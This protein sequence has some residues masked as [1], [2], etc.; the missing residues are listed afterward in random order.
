MNK[1][2][3]QAKK[4]NWYATIF[5]TYLFITSLVLILCSG[6]II[7]WKTFIPSS[8]YVLPIAAR[9]VISI[10][11]G[12]SIVIYGFILAWYKKISIYRFP[13]YIFILGIILTLFW[14]PESETIKVNGKETFEVKWLV[15][16][17]DTVLVFG[18]CAISYLIATFTLNEQLMNKWRQMY[19]KQNTFL[20]NNGYDSNADTTN[21][22]TDSKELSYEV[23]MIKE[24]I[25]NKE[26]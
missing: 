25:N 14:I 17:F 23:D 6:I 24:E 5:Y 22:E 7:P 2:K 8:N 1:K 16:P 18:L 19:G 3:K 11:Y 10:V 9:I 4:R 20:E 13:N 12:F 15:F 21:I 26:N